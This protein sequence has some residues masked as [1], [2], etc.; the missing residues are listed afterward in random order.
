MSDLGWLLSPWNR[1]KSPT[2]SD[3]SDQ[4]D[5]EGN[6]KISMGFEHSHNFQRFCCVPLDSTARI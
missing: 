2:W 4:A 1:F 6:K 3:I 5:T